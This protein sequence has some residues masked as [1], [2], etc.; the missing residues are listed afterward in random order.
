MK[1][2][3]SR[4]KEFALRVIRLYAA[5]P[6]STEAQVLGKQLLRSGTSVGAHYREAIRARSNAE[7]ISKLEGGMQ[8][9]EESSY[10]L[11]LLVEAEI[12]SAEKLN[13]LMTEAN[14]LMAI[15]VT[16]AKNAKVGGGGTQ[17][18]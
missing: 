13:P 10:W 14:E 16:C 9:L 5:L 3:A 4:T 7:F 17:K 11:E 8:E 6:K 15:L 1:D 2:L 12:I 18:P